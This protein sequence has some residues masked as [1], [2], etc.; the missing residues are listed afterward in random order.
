MKHLRAIQNVAEKTAKKYGL[1]VSQVSGFDD[2]TYVIELKEQGD[3][4][5]TVV[6][7]AGNIQRADAG[8]IDSVRGTTPRAKDDRA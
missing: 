4:V 2:G 8:K 1:K 6:G 5:K 3:S 7:F